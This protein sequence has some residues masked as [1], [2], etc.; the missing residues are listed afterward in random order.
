MNYQKVLTNIRISFYYS[1]HFILLMSSDSLDTISF[2][3]QDEKSIIPSE[4]SKQIEVSDS[5]MNKNNKSKIPQRILFRKDEDEKI[6]QLVNIFGTHNWSIIAQFIEGRTAKQCRDRYSNYLIPGY[7]QGE[8]SKE[9]DELLIK[10]Y[11]E[12]GSKWSNIK[13]YFPQRSSNNIKNRWYY[14][15]N[16]KTQSIENKDKLISN[17]NIQLTNTIPE[18]N[19]K[20]NDKQSIDTDIFI[21]NDYEWQ[22][23]QH[24]NYDFPLENELKYDNY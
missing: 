16:K 13:K 21:I 9:E 1:C 10:L 19:E 2:Y 6:K 20:R 4:Q 8:W 18:I 15:L 7:F 17:N 22:L 24:N 12:L 23:F 11:N 3:S 14:F 5:Q